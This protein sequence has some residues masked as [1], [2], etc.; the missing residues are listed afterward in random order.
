MADRFGDQSLPLV[1]LAGPPV[2]LGHQISHLSLQSL[3][4]DVGKE[5]MIAIPAPLLVQGHKEQVGCLECFEYLLA[6][7]SLGDRIAQRAGQPVEDGRLQQKCLDL[8][9]LPDED[10]FGQ[11]V[12]HVALAAAKCPD[13]ARDVLVPLQRQRP[14]SKG[15]QLQTHNPALGALLQ[16]CDVLCREVQRHRLVEIGRCFAGREAQV[17]RVQF[18]QLSPAAQPGEGQ[19][20]VSASSDDKMHSLLE[21]RQV[22]EQER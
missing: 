4:Q 21:G 9:G 2:Q 11:V 5:M 18:G 13:K 10:F 3:A 1:P 6:L 14:Q 20:W 19:G 16:R 12:E 17:S 7:R 8:L 15:G 22:V